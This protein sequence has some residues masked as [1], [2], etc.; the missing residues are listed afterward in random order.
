MINDGDRVLLC[1]SGGKD[2]LSMLHAIRQYQFYARPKVFLLF[3]IFCHVKMLAIF[4]RFRSFAMNRDLRTVGTDF[5]S[6]GRLRRGWWEGRS[7]CWSLFSVG[8]KG[9]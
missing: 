8:F 2:S 5:V 6:S 3:Y 4:Y 9:K 7:L 1:L